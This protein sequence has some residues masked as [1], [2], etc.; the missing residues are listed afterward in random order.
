[1]RKIFEFM[2]RYNGALQVVATLALVIVAAWQA[3]L[4]RQANL[5]SSNASAIAGKAATAAKDNAAA[6]AGLL[7][8]EEQE[9][10][11]NHAAHVRV[12]FS[13]STTVSV[14]LAMKNYGP[15]TIV[16]TSGF[17]W[18][19]HPYFSNLPKST[20]TLSNSG[21]LRTGETTDITIDNVIAVAH[22]WGDGFGSFPASDTLRGGIQVTT[23]AGITTTI[24]FCVNVTVYASALFYGETQRIT[25]TDCD[26]RVGK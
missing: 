1:M 14:T 16:K 15:S 26:P 17:V 5:D 7:K 19:I 23:D 21:E 4:I 13:H 10:D 22:M 25:A 3:I 6:T 2:H 20:L 9:F 12:S 18:K 11:L 24:P 8:I